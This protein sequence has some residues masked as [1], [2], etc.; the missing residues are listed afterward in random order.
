MENT[1]ARRLKNAWNVFTGNEEIKQPF[2]IYEYSSSNRPDRQRLTRGNERSI[3]SAIY[4]RIALDVS[5]VSIIHAKLDEKGRYLEQMD[6]SLNNCLNI[7]ANID[8]T[9][10]SFIQ[11][12]VIS[13]FDEGCI[14]VVPVDTYND[15]TLTE[16]Y[17]IETMR[18]GKIVQWYPE[19]IR[20][21][22]YNQKNG[23]REE[24]TVL[25]RMT[26]IIENPFYTVMNE[27]N[28]ILQRLIQ[29]LNLLDAI[30][31][32]S[33]SGKMDLI[34][35]LPY[36][37]KSESRRKQA[38]ERMAQIEDQLTGSKYGIAYT[39]G[40]E[41]ITQLNRPV[42]NNLMRQIEFLTSMLYSQLGITEEI[43]N[44]SANETTML[45][46]NNRVIE[47]VLSAIVDEY[48]RK[49]LTKTAR[50]QKQTIMFFRDPFRLVPV[51]QIAEI[52]DKFT[53][54]EI[55]TSNEVRQKIGMQP[56]TDPKADE[57]RN[58]NLN[59]SKDAEIKNNVVSNL[60]DDKDLGGEIQNGKEL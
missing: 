43:L 58:K 3:I 25:K 33:G 23:R 11:D 16:S 8:Q 42:E 2:N 56:S 10:R 36:I 15:P 41:K 1:L 14:A 9:A 30:D 20:V 27:Q 57:L 21:L 24:V 17:K 53:R 54:N 34:I 7:E 38:E 51:S 4:N 50:S 47:P 59:P 13:L 45:N 12:I 19:H 40:T 44:G 46:Y 39:D 29:K 31:K 35:Q 26:A 18:V 32:Q 37:V 6:S 48:K 60:A 22:L 49:F 55:L 5:A 28:S 52:A